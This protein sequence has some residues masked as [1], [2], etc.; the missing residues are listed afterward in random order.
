MHTRTRSLHGISW[1]KSKT[2]N[3]IPFIVSQTVDE[4]I[5]RV[6]AGLGCVCVCARL[7]SEWTVKIRTKH[8]AFCF[9]FP[10]FLLF[11][12]HAH[13]ADPFAYIFQ[14]SM[15]ATACLRHKSPFVQSITLKKERKNQEA[16][17]CHFDNCT[18]DAN[19]QREDVQIQVF[20]LHFA[21]KTRRKW[22]CPR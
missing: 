19:G 17:N 18:D 15:Q 9:Y 5:L 6:R 3:L 7:R 20:L 22:F 12:S 1:R 14:V 11:F 16:P 21:S 2:K 10:L 8:L 4:H 13:L